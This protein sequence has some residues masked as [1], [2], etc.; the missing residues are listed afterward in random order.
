MVG[1]SRET[2]G[3]PDAFAC[4]EVLE[5]WT[6]LCASSL[7]PDFVM[8]GVSLANSQQNGSL[9]LLHFLP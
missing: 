9:V 4:G 6:P 3:G 2:P 7:N 5:V 8:G 1:W